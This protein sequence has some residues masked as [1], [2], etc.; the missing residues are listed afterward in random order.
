[1]HGV[2]IIVLKK[3]SILIIPMNHSPI[4]MRNNLEA[5]ESKGYVIQHNIIQFGRIVF[6]DK[7]YS[8]KLCDRQN[9]LLNSNKTCGCFDWNQV[10]LILFLCILF[11]FPLKLVKRRWRENSDLWK[12]WRYS[13]KVTSQ[14]TS[15]HQGCNHAMMLTTI[16]LMFLMK[17]LI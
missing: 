13:Q 14:W 8:A 7:K 1:M 3:Q 10:I 2:P 12:F 9:F 17:L 15:M 4:P 6:L 5:N 16:L 11:V